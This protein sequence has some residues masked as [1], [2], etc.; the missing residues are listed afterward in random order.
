MDLFQKSV[1]LKYSKRKDKTKVDLVYEKYAHHFLNVTIQE[2]SR[3]SKE[4][5][6]QGEFF[7]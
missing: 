4:E 2:N 3:N 1:R 6:Y 5:Q 7:R